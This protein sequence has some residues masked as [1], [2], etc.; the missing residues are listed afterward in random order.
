MSTVVQKGTQTGNERGENDWEGHPEKKGRKLVEGKTRMYKE[1][2]GKST[3][4]GKA[5]DSTLKLS[6][7][8]VC[9]D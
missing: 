9:F 7:E 3:A 8:F 6:Y 2:G 1:N 4:E 5:N